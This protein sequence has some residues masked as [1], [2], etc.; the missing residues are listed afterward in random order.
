MAKR[1]RLY[2]ATDLHGSDKCFRKF[3]NAGEAYQADA[4]ILGGDL[5]G[6]A[7]QAITRTPG[8]RYTCTF[9]GASYELEDGPELTGLE[10]LIADHGYYSYREEPGELAGREAEGKLDDVFM[11]LMRER[12]TRWLSMAD[13]R[14]RPQGRPVCFMLGNDDPPPLAELLDAAPWGTNAEGEVIE[15]DGH[16]VLS[17]GYSNIT[18]FHSYREMS[19]EA[20]ASKFAELTPQ[21]KEPQRAILNLHVPPYGTGLDEAPVIDDSLTV[22]TA[23]G[24]VKFAAVG[25]TAVRDVLQ[26]VQPLLGLHGHIHE[27]PGFR[28]LG[29]TVAI[30]PGS[31]YGTGALNGVLITLDQDRIKAHQ[32]VR[33]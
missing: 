6:K 25:S 10:Q 9:R 24:Q 12:L 20:L 28:K 29:R 22:Q 31:D 19:E 32:F 23:V 4:M 21:L 30:N 2:F 18:P 5:A 13:E 26:E 1:F 33:G 15:L 8:G 17:W 27:S 7:I 14:L 16:E 11:D 3:L